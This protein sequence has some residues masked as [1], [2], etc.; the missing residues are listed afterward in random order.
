MCQGKYLFMTHA[1]PG[2]PGHHHVNCQDSSYWIDQLAKKKYKLLNEDSYTIR[3]LADRD[4]ARHISRNGM[5]FV[6]E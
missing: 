1:I 5:L 4:K 6:K 3:E 2:Q